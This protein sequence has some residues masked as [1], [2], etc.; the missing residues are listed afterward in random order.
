MLELKKY[1]APGLKNTILFKNGSGVS[2]KGDW[3]QIYDATE[4]DRFFIGDFIAADYT[5]TINFNDRIRE[6]I[7]CIVTAGTNDASIM[8]YARTSVGADKVVN[9]SATINNSYVSLI[10]TPVIEVGGVSYAG[11]TVAT[12]PSYH[13]NTAVGS[14]NL[15]G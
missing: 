7:K 14:R 5:L 13:Q 10:A 9:L 1:F 4:V 8:V 2:H 15:A 3:T 6:I 12:S 11:C